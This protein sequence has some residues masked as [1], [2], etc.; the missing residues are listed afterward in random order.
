VLLS[1]RCVTDSWIC[2]VSSLDARLT[3]T[4]SATRQQA[5]S[6]MFGKLL[7]AKVWHCPCATQA[8]CHHC[9][10]HHSAMHALQESWN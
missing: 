6:I 4:A 9:K 3:T 10:K 2:A 7:V 1:E 5:G 8:S